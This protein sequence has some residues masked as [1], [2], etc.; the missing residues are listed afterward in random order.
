MIT[1]TLQRKTNPELRGAK[2]PNKNSDMS[3][4]VSAVGI[5]TL[6]NLHSLELD[7]VRLDEWFYR[8][9]ATASSHSKV[10]PACSTGHSGFIV[11]TG[12]LVGGGLGG[13]RLPPQMKFKHDLFSMYQQNIERNSSL[14]M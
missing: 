4:Y 14:R 13:G 11:I 3:S 7:G 6:N 2:E 5:C 10:N 8:G 9:M 1:C 12:V